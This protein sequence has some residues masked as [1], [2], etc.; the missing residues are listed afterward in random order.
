M[1]TKYVVMGRDKGA[2][3]WKLVR[4]TLSHL[5]PTTITKPL[6]GRTAENEARVLK[7]VREERKQK[8]DRHSY[9]L[10]AVAKRLRKT[11]AWLS[12]IEN[13]RADVP[14]DHRLDA[15][16][17]VYGLKR[18]SFYERVR[19]YREK[20]TPRSELNELIKRMDNEKIKL[21]LTFVKSILENM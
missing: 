10:R 15:L 19:L 9:S 6:D 1:L 18:K 12:Q 5:H 3:T 21:V 14:E 16:L 2:R 8:L 17:S 20:V 13:G 7:E 4:K 11:D